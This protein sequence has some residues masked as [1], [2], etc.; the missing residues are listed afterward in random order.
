M[1]FGSNLLSST[2]KVFFVLLLLFNV[3]ISKAQWFEDWLYLPEKSLLFDYSYVVNTK[4]TEIYPI[5]FGVKYIYGWDEIGV[6]VGA[7]MGGSWKKKMPQFNY[8]E[9]NYNYN[10]LSNFYYLG[11][12]GLEFGFAAIQVGLGQS[13]LGCTKES[14][15]QYINGVY[16]RETDAYIGCPLTIEPSVYFY[17]PIYDAIRLAVK[18]GYQITPKAEIMNAL[19]IGGGILL[20]DW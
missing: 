8:R 18:I 16:K 5:S 11:T 9:N 3:Q 2:L 1:K 7:I 17:I 15:F 6:S 20:G 4:G 19:T 13:V 12:V 14:D 10:V